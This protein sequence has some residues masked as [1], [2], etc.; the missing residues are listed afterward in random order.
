MNK[1]ELSKNEQK[2]KQQK[3]ERIY[4]VIALVVVALTALAIIGVVV[5]VCLKRA[6]MVQQE[7]LYGCWYSED[8]E[9]CWRFGEDEDVYFFGRKSPDDPYLF[10]SY[11][12][13]IVNEQV[14]TVTIML[15]RDNPTVFHC[16]LRGDKLTMTAEETIVFRKGIDIAQ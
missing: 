5:N 10:S 4:S 16:T 15:G 1:T 14:S 12:D 9:S 11:T 2:Q 6:Q 13:Y 8:G 3:Q 7:E